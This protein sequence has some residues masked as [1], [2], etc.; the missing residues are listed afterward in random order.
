MEK[1][2]KEDLISRF[3]RHNPDAQTKEESGDRYHENWK[4][5]KKTDRKPTATVDPQCLIEAEIHKYQKVERELFDKAMAALATVCKFALTP[6]VAS[7]YVKVLGQFGFPTA[8]RAL[9]RV[10]LTRRANDPFPSISDLMSMV[11]SK[12]SDQSSAQEC[13]DKV[14]LA[15]ARFGWCNGAPAR[16]WVGDL[17]AKVIERV[18]WEYLTQ[19]ETSQGPAIRAQLRDAARAILE[20]E[21]FE[22]VNK[23]LGEM[24]ERS[25]L[26]GPNSRLPEPP[27]GG[28]LPDYPGRPNTGTE[29]SK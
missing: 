3:Q 5:N 23:L 22:S 9:Q 10:F 14:W 16:I 19:A 13:A 7:L 11:D 21:R 28:V 27:T 4:Q 24:D 29:E 12:M 15:V 8:T 6:S 18:G 20:S 1:L 25:Q 17:G 26:E 2:N